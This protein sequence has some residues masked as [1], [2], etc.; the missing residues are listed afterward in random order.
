[1]R[2]GASPNSVNLIGDRVGL[3]LGVLS[4]QFPDSVDYWDANWLIIDGHVVHPRGPW[5]F[6]EPCLTSFELQQLAEWFDGVELG[7]LDPDRGYFTEPGLEFS[8][9][10]T[11]EPAVAVLLAHECAPPW[12]TDHHDR[13]DG[14]RLHF[15]LSANRPQVL[16]ASM[17][18]LLARFP[19][20][21]AA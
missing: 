2:T 8:Y 9:V 7:H 20:R 18:D 1:M 10:A 5:A 3:S 16:A 15:P 11:P 19:V 13:L 12:I 6:R 21:Y 14:I 4:Y 17:R